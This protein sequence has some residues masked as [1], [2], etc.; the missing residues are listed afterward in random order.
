VAWGCPSALSPAPRGASQY[1]TGRPPEA[2]RVPADM[3]LSRVSGLATGRARELGFCGPGAA[4]A[5]PGDLACRRCRYGPIC[6]TILPRVCRPATRVSAW[7]AWSNG[8]TASTWGRSVPASTRRPSLRPLPAAVG[9]ERFA[10]DAPL[11]LSG[12][13]LQDYGDHPAAVADRADSLARVWPPARRGLVT[14][15]SPAQ[16]RP[17]R[18]ATLSTAA[19]RGPASLRRT[20]SWPRPPSPR[21]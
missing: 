15:H 7:R 14:A 2:A 17:R 13:A 16:D 1:V 10:G 12:Q 21:R 5:V 4:R 19:M 6:S 9:G 20:G 3:A 11:Q 8:S 18:A